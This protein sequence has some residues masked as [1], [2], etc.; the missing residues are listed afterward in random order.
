M[1]ED[2]SHQKSTSWLSSSRYARHFMLLKKTR[3]DTVQEMGS[4]QP[5]FSS[6]EAAL[7]GMREEEIALRTRDSHIEE[8]LLL[9]LSR[10]RHFCRKARRGLFPP[11]IPE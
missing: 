9:T 4:L 11:R 7:H 2:E 10:S 5:E 8:T 6:P 1:T 3:L